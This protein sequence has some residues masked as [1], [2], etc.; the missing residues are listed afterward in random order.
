MDEPRKEACKNHIRKAQEEILNWAMQLCGSGMTNGMI[1]R[2][3]EKKLQELK[4]G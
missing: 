1:R 4:N 3:L 2:L